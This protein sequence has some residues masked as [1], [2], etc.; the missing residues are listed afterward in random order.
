LP[1]HIYYALYRDPLTTMQSLAHEYGDVVLLRIGRQ[2]IYILNHPTLVEEAVITNSHQTSKRLGSRLMRRLLGN[3][4]MSSQDEEHLKQR[5]MLQPLFH[6]RH[7]A[8]FGETMVSCARQVSE[9]WQP[10]ETLDVFEEMTDLA[11][12]VVGKTLFSAEF[13]AQAE[14]IRHALD[15][16]MGRSRVTSLVLGELAEQLPLPTPRRM[17]NALRRLD[18]SIYSLIAER[19]RQE[20]RGDLLALLLEAEDEN[21][22][23]S[24]TQIRDQAMT[25]FLAGFETM[26]VTLTWT[27]YLLSQHPA[28]ER[29]FQAEIDQT[30]AGRL[31]TADDLPKL[32][33]THQLLS[34]VL[35]IYPPVWTHGRRLAGAIRLGDWDLPA[36]A[37]IIF[38]TWLLHHD[39]RYYADPERFDPGRWTDEPEVKRPRMSFAPFGAGPRQC[40]GE[41]FAW[42]EGV[43]LLAT[44]AQSW[45]LRLAPGHPVEV[46]PVLTLRPR[47]GMRMTL[48]RRAGL[49]KGYPA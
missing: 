49:V 4:V 7:L 31:P 22:K 5:R 48:S 8:D 36:G 9:R 38:N 47:Y 13:D 1:L 14:E 39:E 15:V 21:G 3:S 19:R 10:G 32:S 11:M 2:P 40:I 27:W 41:G 37:Y 46:E 17:H 26:A 33:Y 30:L 25:I 29:R 12:A 20:P 28:I 23:L 24:D 34:E 16:F 43:L 35:R 44:L 18:H 6:R 42:M 45:Q